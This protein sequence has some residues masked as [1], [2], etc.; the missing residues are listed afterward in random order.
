MHFPQN[1]LARAE[2]YTIANT[3]NQYLVPTDGKPIRVY[4]HV[5]PFA[6]YL[7]CVY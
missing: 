7:P 6:C 5:C 1:E 4:L 3:D 2:L